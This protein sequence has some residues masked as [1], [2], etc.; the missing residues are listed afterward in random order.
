ML[1]LNSHQKTSKNIVSIIN[2]RVQ[3]QKKTVDMLKMLL[4]KRNLLFQV[5]SVSKVYDL[6]QNKNGDSLDGNQNW[7]TVS[8]LKSS[9][10]I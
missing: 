10:P 9:A 8:F 7:T 4:S 1:P 5:L 3:T 2:I 6:L